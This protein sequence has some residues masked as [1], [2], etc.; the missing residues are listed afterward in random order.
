[1]IIEKEK[2]LVDESKLSREEIPIFVKFLE[3]EKQ[4]H[5]EDIEN[6][7]KT[8]ENLTKHNNDFKRVPL[9]PETP[10]VFGYQCPKCK[11]I[12]GSC[13]IGSHVCSEPIQKP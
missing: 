12:V 8:I 6:I 10:R 1:M 13:E 11:E 3:M 9:T 7:E 4:R 5:I 2:G